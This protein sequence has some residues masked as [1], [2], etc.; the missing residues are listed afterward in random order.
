MASVWIHLAEKSS[1]AMLLTHKKRK[2]EDCKKRMT[3]RRKKN[4]TT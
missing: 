3:F 1:I 4:K 2:V